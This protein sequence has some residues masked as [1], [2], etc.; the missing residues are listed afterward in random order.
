MK[1]RCTGIKRRKTY[2]ITSHIQ[3]VIRGHLITEK[4]VT[5]RVFS[6]QSPKTATPTQNMLP[7]WGGW[8]GKSVVSGERSVL[9]YTWETGRQALPVGVNVQLQPTRHPSEDTEYTHKHTTCSHTHTHTHTHNTQQ[10]HEYIQA[11]IGRGRHTV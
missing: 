2:S 6:V 7:L 3:R 11:V 10:T 9:E 8:G 1:G 5:K 4:C